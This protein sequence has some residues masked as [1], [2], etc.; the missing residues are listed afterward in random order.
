MGARFIEDPNVGLSL[1]SGWGAKTFLGQGSFGIVSLWEYTGR[2]ENAPR[3]TQIALN[4]TS[5]WN[6]ADLI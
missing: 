3:T 2:R 6:L 4:N 5:G 1:G